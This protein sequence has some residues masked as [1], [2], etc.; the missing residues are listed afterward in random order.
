MTIDLVKS[1]TANHR[2]ISKHNW[3]ILRYAVN[4]GYLEEKNN[5][6]YG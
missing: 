5:Y 3:F 1:R 4:F 2:L 6:K